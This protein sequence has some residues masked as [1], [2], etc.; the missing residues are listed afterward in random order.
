MRSYEK[1]TY[2]TPTRPKLKI[3]SSDINKWDN[4][5]FLSQPKINGSNAVIFMN[6]DTIKIYNRTGTQ[7]S[8]VSSEL[9]FRKL[10]RGKGWMVLNGEY[11]NKNKFDESNKRFNHKL[12]LFDILV[13]ESKYL[14][15]NTFEDRVNLLDNIYGKTESEKDYLYNIDEN[16]YR[17]KSY[18][19][20][21]QELYNNLIKI[22][23][24][25]GLVLKFKNSKLELS[26]NSKGLVKIRKST[27][28]YSY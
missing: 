27:S 19:D 15:G 23:M 1:F 4:S 8:N 17:V 11:L 13:Y 7:L 6:E 2:I 3:T 25:E 21:F 18:N 20:N 10:Y 22:D 24:V 16:F 26:N 28:N 5:T 9:N 12:I 14:I